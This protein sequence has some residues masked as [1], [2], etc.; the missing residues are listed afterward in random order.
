MDSNQDT[1]S[2]TGSYRLIRVLGSG[3]MGIVHEAWD[4]RLERRV[5]LKMIH[6]HLLAQPP[7]A[8]RFDQEAKRAARIEHPN[9]VRVYRI[10]SIEG[11]TVIEM[12]YVDG[13]TLTSLLRSGPLS[14]QHAAE[15]L[16]QVLEALQACHEHG[17]IH[18]DLKPANLLIMRNGQVML[19]DFGIARALH[20]GGSTE[21]PSGPLSGPIWG[22]PQYCPPEAWESEGVTPQWD[23]YSAGVLTYET[24]SGTPPFRG[25]TP[26]SLM[27]AVLFDSPMPLKSARPDVSDAFVELIT[28]MMARAPGDRPASARAALQLLLKV[29][30]L[31]Q[32]PESTVALPPPEIDRLPLLPQTATTS[33]HRR[34]WFRAALSSLVLVLLISGLI[35]FYYSA[36]QTDTGS[37]GAA[38]SEVPGVSPPKDTGISDMILLQG[39]PYFSFDDGVHGRELWCLNERIGA[40]AMVADIE[41]GPASSNPR[42]FLERPQG[43]FVFAATTAATGEELWYGCDSG[44]GNYSARI[45][46]DIITGPMGSNPLPVGAHGT[47][48]YFYATT[49]EAG[50]ELWCSNTIEGQTAMVADANKGVES[51]EPMSPRFFVDDDCAYIVAIADAVRGFTLYKYNFTARTLRELGTVGSETVYMANAGPRLLF[52]STDPEHGYELWMFDE[53]NQAPKLLVDICPG[54]A[55]SNP[56]QFS[57]WKDHV[58]FQARTPDTGLELWISDGTLDGTRLVRDINPGPDDSDPYGFLAVGEWAFFRAKDSACGLELWVTNGTPDGTA[59]VADIFPGPG[60]GNP[61]NITARGQ[62]VFFTANDSVHGEELWC[63]TYSEG[64]WKAKLVADVL[65][66]PQGSEPHRLQW[67][68]KGPGYFLAKDSGGQSGLYSLRFSEATPWIADVSFIPVKSGPRLQ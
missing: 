22:T 18:C 49:L 28:S 11:R 21:A 44:G 12:Q 16:K 29:P 60:H 59:R 65:T 64:T 6:P 38:T 34:P 24:L 61:Y 31:Q 45:V 58:L 7:I 13:A 63:C 56:S 23:L 25:P 43:G 3:G 66:G 39:V 9:V 14:P 2:Y 37:S 62:N 68:E 30:E 26:A 15:V 4:T 67:S 27:R 42:R 47:L 33:G 53:E 40:P 54:P 46:K 50:R 52:A 57:R 8:E 48:V 5:A 36:V 20:D 10:D 35:L 55:P 41:P 17:V 19:S 1:Q 32:S 51:S